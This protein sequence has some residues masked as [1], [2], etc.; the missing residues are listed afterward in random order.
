MTDQ[1]GPRHRFRATTSDEWL[2]GVVAGEITPRTITEAIAVAFTFAVE[3]AIGDDGAY[4]HS[5]ESSTR[6]DWEERIARSIRVGRE[7]LRLTVHGARWLRLDEID[8]ALNSI[9]LGGYFRAR[10]RAFGVDDTLLYTTQ[11]AGT[12]A[13]RGLG[14]RRMGAD[15]SVLEALMVDIT[16]REAQ[17]RTD[18]LRLSKMQEHA[19]AS[20]RKIGTT[21]WAR[22]YNTSL[23]RNDGEDTPIRV[24]ID[25][26][27]RVRDTGVRNL[28]KIIRAVL[29]E[30]GESPAWLIH[31]K[32]ARDHPG[33]A[34]KR[35]QDSLSKQTA[36]GKIIRVRRGVY[37]L[38]RPEEV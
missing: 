6:R 17:V 34:A 27:L 21:T 31:E 18:L 19:Q 4:R 22:V 12:K 1:R 10:L 24:S 7:T 35:V 38:P 14:A 37:R 36:D 33:I 29:T 23:E 15:Q 3:D 32:V 8:A 20:G 11:K 2:A 13:S 16:A 5:A 28:S 30:H 9:I 25:R 26:D